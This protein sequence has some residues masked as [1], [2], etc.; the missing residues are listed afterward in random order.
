MTAPDRSP[1]STEP[2]EPT[3]PPPQ[4]AALRPV[5]AKRVQLFAAYRILTV[6]AGADFYL[7]AMSET[8]PKVVWRQLGPDGAMGAPHF[9][10]EMHGFFLFLPGGDRPR[11]GAPMAERL[12]WLAA[13][14]TEQTETGAATPLGV[15]QPLRRDGL[16]VYLPFRVDGPLPGEISPGLEPGV[17]SHFILAGAVVENVVVH[18]EIVRR[19]VPGR[20]LDLDETLSLVRGRILRLRAA[21]GFIDAAPA[22]AGSRFGRK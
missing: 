13:K 8:P 19:G 15:T 4:G 7:D 2:A 12:D 22:P 18:M 14:F 10:G 16:G 20:T 21:N 9:P 11:L 3:A 5:R 1:Q 6:T 17:E